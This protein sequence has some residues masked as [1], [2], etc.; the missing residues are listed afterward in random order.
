MVRFALFA[1]IVVAAL[2]VYAQQPSESSATGIRVS[3][4][5]S[6]WII[7][8]KKNS[9]TLNP[10]DFAIVVQAGHVP[11]RMVPS[12][13]KD[14]IVH[15]GDDEFSLRFTDAREIR[16]TPHDTGFKSGIKITLAGFPHRGL[17]G[18]GSPLD[19]RLVFT[20]C[21]DGG[22][23]ELVFEAMANEGE[24]KVRELNW[25]MAF[26]GREIDYT[27]LAN[28]DGVLLPRDWPK[29]YHPINRA[30]WDTSIIQSNLIESWSMSWWGFQKGVAAAIVIVETPDDAGYTFSHPAG[31]PTSIGPS[32]RPALGSFGYVR[33][34][35]MDFLAQGNY[36][37]LAKRYRQ[38]VMDTGLYVSLKDKIARSPLVKNLIGNPF[39][40]LSVLRNYKAGGARYDEKNPQNNYRLTTFAQN[41]QR[42]RDLKAKGFDN[43]NVSIS[44][45]LQFGYDR[46]TPDALPPAKEAGGWEG[47]KALFDTCK[48]LGYVCWLHDQYRDYYLDAPSWNPEFAVHEEDSVRPTAAFPGTRFK[49]RWKEG[50]IPYMDNWDGGTQSYLNS[51]YML[52]HVQKNYRMLWEHGIRPQGSYQDVFGY[53]PPDQDF[54]PDHP[55]THTESMKHRA[56][57]MQW[58]RRHLG[59]VGTEDGAD[60]VIPYTDYVT[61]RL[62]RN[63]A[64][65]ND[66]SSEGA[67]DIPLYELVYHDAVV[68]SYSVIPRG[69]LHGSAPSM[70]STGGSEP[71]YDE[72]RRMAALHMRVGLVEMT[73]HEFLDRD[74]HRERTTFADGTTV[75]V[76]WEKQTVEIAPD[77]KAKK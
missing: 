33:T 52:G 60:W 59:I 71:D 18:L 24:A 42:L 38:Y 77:L 61:S 1:V 64:S 65:G 44:G 22:T 53:V 45:W 73:N 66:A 49:K 40:G 12:S 75:T 25:P 46:Q 72:V 74:R 17:R 47:M 29:R 3:H 15:S 28:D 9:V 39:T 10:S 48:E 55:N 16:I 2:G 8:G 76:D 58:T 34:L 14:L 32:W 68:T 30:E 54:N 26:D 21:L 6:K 11:W 56:A 19:L 36:V 70:R 31:G 69:F 13:D 67:I 62:N 23:E 5:A 4:T 35:R 50:Y 43:L 7:A 51:R 41:A 37:T 57:V 20:M 27:V 63:P